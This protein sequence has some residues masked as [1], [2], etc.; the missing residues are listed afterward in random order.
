MVC[1]NVVCAGVRKHDEKIAAD[2]EYQE[3]VWENESSVM[4]AGV[5]GGGVHF[6]QF[7]LELDLANQQTAVIGLQCTYR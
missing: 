2:G 7:A 5:K 3:C 1:A 6:D 4:V